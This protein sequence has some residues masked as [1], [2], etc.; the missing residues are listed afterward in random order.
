MPQRQDAEEEQGPNDAASGAAAALANRS[1]SNCA[2]VTTRSMLWF[3]V[4]A[5]A[6]SNK[7][8]RQDAPAHASRKSRKTAANVCYKGDCIVN[9]MHGSEQVSQYPHVCEHVQALDADRP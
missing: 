5:V 1:G 6:D 2:C 9:Y 8:E 7:A 4:M 3:L